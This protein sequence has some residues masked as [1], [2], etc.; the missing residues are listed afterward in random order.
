MIP[1]KI[2]DRLDY[3]VEIAF[4]LFVCNL[5]EVLKFRAD[6]F[7]PLLFDESADAVE[8]HLGHQQA[9]HGFES[10]VAHVLEQKL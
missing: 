1:F 7:P 6:G 2:V 5:L 8:P 9:D 10:F 3:N 4:G